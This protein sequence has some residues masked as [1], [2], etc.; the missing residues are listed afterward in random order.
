M[1][2]VSWTSFW[3][4]PCLSS[5]DEVFPG[6]DSFNHDGAMV[7]SWD[8]IVDIWIIPLLGVKVKDDD[9]VELVL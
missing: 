9:V 6:G 7:P 2:K 4:I 3:E 8:I 5:E 1:A